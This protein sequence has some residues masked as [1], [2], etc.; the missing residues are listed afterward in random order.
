MLCRLSTTI[1]RT[2]GRATPNT[3]QLV[4]RCSIPFCYD[5]MQPFRNIKAYQKNW[6]FFEDALPN[7][8][9]FRPPLLWTLNKIFVLMLRGLL[10]TFDY[11]AGPCSPKHNPVPFTVLN[12]FFVWMLCKHLKTFKTMAPQHPLSRPSSFHRTEKFFRLD[13]M[14]TFN[15]VQINGCSCHPKH[16]PAHFTMLKNFFVWLFWSFSKTVNSTVGPCSSKHGPIPFTMLKNLFVWMLCSR[17]RTFKFKARP[18]SPTTPI[19]AQVISW[20][21]RIF[22]VMMLCRL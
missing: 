22:L 6:Y 20:R 8:F 12:N 3:A 5:A 10:K 19:T 18:R 2:A 14:Q 7:I 4:S 1:K 11:K 17:L 9:C 21:W 16:G 13:V 15:N